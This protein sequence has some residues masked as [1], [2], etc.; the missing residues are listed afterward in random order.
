MEKLQ[1]QE[2]LQITVEQIKEYMRWFEKFSGKWKTVKIWPSKTETTFK[3]YDDG[4]KCINV[5]NIFM[6]TTWECYPK[7]LIVNVSHNND[8]N[9]LWRTLTEDWQLDWKRL[10]YD[11]KWF[12]D[13]VP[14]LK[15]KV[16]KEICKLFSDK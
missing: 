7:A 9:T 6:D 12:H 16:S 5:K 10:E 4:A 2:K 3:S 1:Q 14:S 13:C 11:L 15:E 8:T